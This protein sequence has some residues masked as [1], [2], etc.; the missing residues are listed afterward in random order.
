MAVT[1]GAQ[2]RLEQLTVVISFRCCDTGQ[3]D[4]WTWR[5]HMVRSFGLSS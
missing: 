1:H 2:L 4:C 3:P 5:L